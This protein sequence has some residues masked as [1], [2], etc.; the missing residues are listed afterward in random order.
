MRQLTYTGPN[1]I[2]WLD[3]PEPKLE[4]PGEAL[5]RPTIVAR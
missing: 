1:T 2:E 4:G 3:V 5:V